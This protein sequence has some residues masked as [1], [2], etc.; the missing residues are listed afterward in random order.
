MMQNA[1][2]RRAV[3]Q[4]IYEWET[5]GIRRDVKIFIR[6]AEALLRLFQLG[7]R[8]I[9]QDD[10]IKALITRRISSGTGSKFKQ[11]AS[12]VRQ[13]TLE[14]NGFGA[15]FLLASALIPKGLLVIGAFVIT[16][17]RSILFIHIK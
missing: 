12:F 10:L 1:D 2:H 11:D 14:G 8:I 7:A 13:Q 4:A 5:V 16:N 3:E 15:V 6:A 9:E 17:G